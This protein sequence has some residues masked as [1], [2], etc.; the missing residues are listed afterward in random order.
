MLHLFVVPWGW[1]VIGWTLG[2]MIPR[3]VAAPV[4]A[5]APW[6]S[7][8]ATHAMS[9]FFWR[10]PGGFITEGSTLT[11]V[12]DPL[13]FVV[14]WLATAA[15]AA[16]VVMLTGARR[17]PW[18]PVVTVTV[19]VEALVVGRAV[20]T[21]WGHSPTREPRAGPPGVRRRRTSPLRAEPPCSASATRVTTL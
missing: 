4:A 6:V 3:A 2:V 8:T 15:L 1:L 21:D 7:L 19:A 18:L 10:H 13:V 11:D 14:P 5:A 12:L 16:A 17:R 9:A 20:V